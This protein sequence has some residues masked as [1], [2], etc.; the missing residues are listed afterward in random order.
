MCGVAWRGV[1]WRGV[2]YGDMAWR[3]VVWGGVVWGGVVL[4]GVLLFC[5]AWELHCVPF[6]KPFVSPKGFS[7]RKD[8]VH[9]LMCVCWEGGPPIRLP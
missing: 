6:V 3:G 5:V 4:C 7:A 2:V 8:S 9:L 1:A